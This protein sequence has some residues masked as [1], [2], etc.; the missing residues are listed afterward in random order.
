MPALK[1]T[2]K[3]AASD[4]N[5]KFVG[6]D[7]FYYDMET[8][9]FEDYEFVLLKEQATLPEK[10]FEGMEFYILEQRSKTND[11]PYSKSIVYQNKKNNF[12][13]KSEAFD[14]NGN[15]WKTLYVLGIKESDGVLIP[16]DTL[17]VNHIDN[18]KTRMQVSDIKTNIGVS[19]AIFTIQNLEK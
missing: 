5:A 6:S 8:K 4:K 1:K 7:M 16:S 12:I 15:L 13:Y 11:S 18:S 2:R 9:K 3:I 14:K 17:I 10:Q 19:D